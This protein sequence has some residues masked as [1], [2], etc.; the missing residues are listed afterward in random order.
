M[1]NDCS[2]LKLK[3]KKGWQKNKEVFTPLRDS[4]QADERA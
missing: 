2:V 3:R 1:I 4:D